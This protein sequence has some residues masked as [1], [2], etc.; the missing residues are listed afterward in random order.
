[1]KE[2]TTHLISTKQ[3]KIDS[4]DYFG[5]FLFALDFDD[6]FKH[7]VQK[8]LVDYIADIKENNS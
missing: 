8:R 5:E 2:L 4:K 3:S 7:I 6:Y 1:M